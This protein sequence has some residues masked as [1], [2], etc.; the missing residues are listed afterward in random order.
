LKALSATDETEDEI[1]KK[2]HLDASPCTKFSRFT[3]GNRENDNTKIAAAGFSVRT[4]NALVKNGINTI[5]ELRTFYKK[6]GITGL[7][8]IR[9]LGK[10]SINEIIDKGILLES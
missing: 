9:N 4:T 2:F 1:I 7:T 8:G 3:L 6:T 5:G 10:T